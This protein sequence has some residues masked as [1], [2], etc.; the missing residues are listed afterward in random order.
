M[1]LQW[2]SSLNKRQKT[3][4]YC[5]D[6]SGAFDRVD[7]P[8]MVAK[9]QSLGVHAQLVSVFT[10]W[11][12]QRAA[13]LVVEGSRS[14]ALQLANMV[15]QGTVF[16]PTLWNL[17]YADAS[18][19][20]RKKGFAELVYADDLNAYKEFDGHTPNDTIVAQTM[21]CQSELHAW[22]AANRV[23]FDP[24]KESMHVVSHVDPHSEA[25]RILVVTFDC[26]LLMATS[27]HELVAE[28]RWKIRTLLRATCFMSISEQVLQFKARL[29]SYVEYRTQVFTMPA[30][31]SWT[32]SMQCREHV[33]ER[34]A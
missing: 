9:L 6:V 31:H 20:I 4:V 3:A 10:S 22:G 33:S 5:A 15:Y 19:A 16:G 34:W 14:E 28:L 8:R 32:G 12:Q 25:F 2:I 26:K 30:A 11:L 24:S 17:F 23:S 27:V 18:R 7:T 29:L 13:F 21:Q 1:T